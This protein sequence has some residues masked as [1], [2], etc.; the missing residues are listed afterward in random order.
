MTVYIDKQKQRPTNTLFSRSL[1][2]ESP[3]DY[4]SRLDNKL[5][6]ELRDVA[7]MCRNLKNLKYESWLEKQNGNESAKKNYRYY[8][9]LGI[10]RT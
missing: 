7:I 10:K 9:L 3:K 4:L 5:D 8:K 1:Y 6:E 2:H